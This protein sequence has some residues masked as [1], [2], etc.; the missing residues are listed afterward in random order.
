[1]VSNRMIL[2]ASRCRHDEILCGQEISLAI[3]LY[4]LQLCSMWH[5]LVES[6]Y[7]SSRILQYQAKTVGCLMSVMLRI[8]GDSRSNFIHE[9]LLNF[10]INFSKQF[11]LL[12]EFLLK[13]CERKFPKKYILYFALMSG[14]SLEFTSNNPTHYPLDYGDFCCLA[15]RA[16]LYA[17]QSDEGSCSPTFKVSPSQEFYYE[18]SFVVGLLVTISLYLF[19]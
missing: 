8:D 9:L 6:T 13:I 7:S 4:S 19:V 18:N 12:S 1:M 5:R 14:S 11:Y 2:V 17:H 15:C 3:N 16:F 10:F